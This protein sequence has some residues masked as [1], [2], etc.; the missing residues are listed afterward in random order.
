[1]IYSVF[2]T[3]LAVKWP[4]DYDHALD[5]ELGSS[6]NFFRVLFS[7]LSDSQTLLEH[8]EE[9]AS[10]IP[11][12]RNTAPGIYKYIAADGTIQCERLD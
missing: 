8:K 12:Q 1:M 7:Y 10:Y 4:Q 3:G 9:D 2:S 5:K 11:L 6:V